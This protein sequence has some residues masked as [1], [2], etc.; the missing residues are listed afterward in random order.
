MA[1]PGIV[2]ILK[3][4]LN[5]GAHSE[6]ETR[7]FQEVGHDELVN[8]LVDYLNNHRH[9]LGYCQI[10]VHQALNEKG[11]DVIVTT[12]DCKVGFQ[13]KSHF[14]VTENDFAAKVKRQFAE[15]F[16]HALDHY[17]ILICAPLVTDKG[18]DYRGKINNIM[19]ELS[20]FRKVALDFY[21][22][23][24]TVGIFRKPPKVSREE[25]LLSGAITDECLHE[26]EKGYEH[27]PS[28]EDEE[29][30]AL[31]EVVDSFGDD[32]FESEEGM[33]SLDELQEL[34][35]KKEKEKFVSTFLPTLPPDVAKRRAELVAQA[36]F[37]LTECRKCKSWDEKSELKLSSW[38]EHIPEEMISCTSLPNLLHIVENLKEYLEIHH[39]MDKELKETS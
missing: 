4:L 9:F 7:F 29:L 6:E 20:L 10:E 39:R 12:G 35:W 21:G 13:I 33:R 5:R 28:V 25:L 38:I 31:R 23:R 26:Y 3:C 11:V 22:P 36:Q 8:K 24:T 16:S 15:S 30:R 34:M 27:L 18:K 32:L 37:L 19:N 17:F 14:D 1:T 2:S